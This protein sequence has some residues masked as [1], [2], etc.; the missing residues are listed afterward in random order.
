MV[1]AGNPVNLYSIQDA[2]HYVIQG[3]ALP[4]DINDLVP[5]GVR[6]NYAGGYEITLSAF[7]GLFTHQ[8]VYLE[9]KLLNLVHNLTAGGYSFTT[10]A[11]TFED[12]FVLRYTDGTSLGTGAP[13]FG[14][15]TVVV[16]KDQ[17]GISINTSNV[18][19]S[20]VKIFDVRGRLIAEK[21]D[22][23]ATTYQFTNLPE[24]QEVLLVKV[25]SEDG[26]SVTKKLVY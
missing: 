10:E 24:T 12:R 20:S 17:H 7:D 19:M 15:N 26:A 11:G 16:F 1:E 22:V 18:M 3:R 21:D 5:L 14:E 8:E 23:G 6:F 4:F 13:V 25:V 9:D 2:G